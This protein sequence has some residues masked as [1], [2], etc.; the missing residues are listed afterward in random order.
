MSAEIKGL[1]DGAIVG[2]NSEVDRVSGNTVNKK[3]DVCLCG[4]I[5]RYV[6]LVM[7][8]TDMESTGTVGMGYQGI[9]NKGQLM[10]G[11]GVFRIT[12]H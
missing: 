6:V 2:I 9:R 5:L 10:N 12:S 8:E 3:A 1:D 11:S 4:I 7:V